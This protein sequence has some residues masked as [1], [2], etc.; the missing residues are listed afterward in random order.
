MYAVNFFSRITGL[1]RIMSAVEV[2]KPCVKDDL[3]LDAVCSTT[4]LGARAFTVS[5]LKNVN[6]LLW[7]LSAICSMTREAVYVVD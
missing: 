4:S 2:L 3:V 6:K 1:Y 7:I 5:R